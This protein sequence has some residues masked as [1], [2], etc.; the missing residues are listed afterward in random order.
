M[1]IE[2]SNIDPNERVPGELDDDDAYVIKKPMSD[3][4]IRKKRVAKKD[5]RLQ[6]KEEEEKADTKIEIVPR[7]TMEDYDIDSLAETLAI[8]KKMLRTRQR[9][10]IIDGSYGRFS[11]EDHDD[12]PTWFTEDEKKHNYKSLPITKEQFEREKNRLMAI[13]A[14]VPKKIMEA[15]IRK[16][17]KMM[18]K[19]KKTKQQ[20]EKVM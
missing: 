9:E 2:D 4:E 14:K 20:A 5:K 12:L 6:Q 8:A 10:E 18:R 11:F 1:E 7:K 13:N 17:M 15:K 3:L 16:K 19:L